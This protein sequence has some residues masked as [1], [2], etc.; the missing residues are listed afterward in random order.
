MGVGPGSYTHLLD[1]AGSFFLSLT[2]SIN[3]WAVLLLLCSFLLP[4]VPSSFLLTVLSID[5]QAGGSTTAYPGPAL[6]VPG[7]GRLRRVTPNGGVT[8]PGTPK[9]LDCST[10]LKVVG[11]PWRL[12]TPKSWLFSKNK[13]RSSW[14]QVKS[15]Y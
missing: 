3:F 14:T 10:I 15:W 11:R 12:T 4:P 13:S 2:V 5:L 7:L 1:F 8:Q 6:E 9:T